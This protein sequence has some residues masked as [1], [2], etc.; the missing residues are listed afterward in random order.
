MAK[1]RDSER[2]L[3]ETLSVTETGP[4]HAAIAS[5]GT[6]RDAAHDPAVRGMNCGIDPQAASAAVTSAVNLDGES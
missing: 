4:F 6:K 3:V 1:F 2:H 5:I